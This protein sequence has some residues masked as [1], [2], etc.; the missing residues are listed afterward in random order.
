MCLAAIYWA[1]IS[2]IYFGNTRQDAAEIG[3]DDDHIYREI[4]LPTEARS[5]PMKR[6][7]ADEAVRA[8]REWGAKPDKV[9]Y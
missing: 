8:F 2:R 5:V 9:R 7:L 3:F 1:R 6:L 4:R